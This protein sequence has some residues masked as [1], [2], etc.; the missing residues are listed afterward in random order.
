MLNVRL[1]VPAK[2]DYSFIFNTTPMPSIN[3]DRLVNEGRAIGRDI[4]LPDHMSH[5]SEL[6]AEI[7]DNDVVEDTDEP[8]REELLAQAKENGIKVRGNPGIPKLLELIEKGADGEEEKEEEKVSDG[9]DSD[10]L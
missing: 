3:W 8:T 5:V 1:I 7:L 10:T 6:E 4:P 9:N 2:W